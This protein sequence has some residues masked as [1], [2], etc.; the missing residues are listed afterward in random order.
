MKILL[1]EDDDLQRGIA[2]R[3]LQSASHE[4]HEVV[5]GE[6]AVAAASSDD[7]DLILMDIRMPGNVDGIEATRLIRALPGS[8]G[9]VP[10]VAM[11][12]AQMMGAVWRSQGFDG[13]LNKAE[14][15]NPKGFADQIIAAMN[16]R[17]NNKLDDTVARSDN[18]VNNGFY[19]PRVLV[20]SVLIGLPPLIGSGAWYMSSQES[21]ALQLAEKFTA[22][23]LQLTAEQTAQNEQI[24][25][26]SE[27]QH[28]LDQRLTRVEA[29]VTF[30][31][32]ATRSK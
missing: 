6:A 29:Q 26:N 28:A 27:A 21:Q 7:F 15:F 10:I 12:V 24:R 1:V 4:V 11:T 32:S 5:N 25:Q 22:E 8:R 17:N 31:L 16:A 18:A 20:F 2:K 3:Y 19:V 9:Q 14:S 23:R 13:F 30:L